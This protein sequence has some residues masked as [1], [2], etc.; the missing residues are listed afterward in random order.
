MKCNETMC[1]WF[2]AFLL[3]PFVSLVKRLIDILMVKF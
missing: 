2:S 3:C 1:A